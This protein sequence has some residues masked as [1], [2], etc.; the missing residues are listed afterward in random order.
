[1]I[2]LLSCKL[3][4]VAGEVIFGSGIFLRF[5]DIITL[6]VVV[7]YLFRSYPWRVR[8]EIGSSIFLFKK[9]TQIIYNRSRVTL[10]RCNRVC[11]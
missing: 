5:V 1:M 10:V 11:N 7:D 8:V 2:S 9:Q 6:P 4:Y 3:Q